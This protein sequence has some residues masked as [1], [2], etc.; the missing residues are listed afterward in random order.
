MSTPRPYIATLPEQDLLSRLGA[1]RPLPPFAAYG[2]TAAEA[3]SRLRD[4]E[5]DEM[6]KF[7]AL[8]L[9]LRQVYLDGLRDIDL[10]VLLTLMA[11]HPNPVTM[12]QVRKDTAL[13]RQ[14]A[15]RALSSNPH[16]IRLE[17]HDQGR[18]RNYY[19]LTKLGTQTCLRLL[20]LIMKQP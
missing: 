17:T 19:A 20:R 11:H 9:F 8:R 2:A 16:L 1:N 12:T 10:L 7:H 18:A 13:A 3:V 15:N 14:T 6:L 4:A 5:T